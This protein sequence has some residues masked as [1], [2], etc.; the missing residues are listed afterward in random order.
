MITYHTKII[1]NIFYSSFSLLRPE[2]VESWFYLWRITKNQK[3]RDW[4]WDFFNSLKANAKLDN[5]R[6]YA[7][8]ASVKESTTQKRDKMESFFLAETLQYLFLL[9]SDD[10]SC[11]PLDQYVFNTEAHIMLIRNSNNDMMFD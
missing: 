7:S 10:E 4:G 11:L 6:G 1:S 9:F 8:V 5:G 3:Y 2:S